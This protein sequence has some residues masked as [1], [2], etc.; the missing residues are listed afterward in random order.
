VR[1]FRLLPGGAVGDVAGLFAYDPSFS[2][3]VFV[4]GTP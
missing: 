4:A 1:V 3:G 2:G